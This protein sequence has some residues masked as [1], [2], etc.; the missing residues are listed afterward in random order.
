MMSRIAAKTSVTLLLVVGAL[1]ITTPPSF[2]DAE[3]ILTPSASFTLNA[4]DVFAVTWT[5][6]TITDATPISEWQD[7]TLTLMKDGTDVLTIGSVADDGHYDWLV[8]DGLSGQYQ[9]RLNR[10]SPVE[11]HVSEAFTIRDADLAFTAPD[12]FEQLWTEGDMV[13]VSW[14]GDAGSLAA[15]DIALVATDGSAETYTIAS[16]IDPASGSVTTQITDAVAVR[17]YE[18]QLRD[19]TNFFSSPIARL[20]HDIW[21]HHLPGPYADGSLLR[22]EGDEVV[23]LIKVLPNGKEFKRHVLTWD[24][25]IWYPHLGNFWSAVTVVPEGTMDNYTTSAWIRLPLTQDTET[26]KVYEVNADAT[27]HWLTCA[28]SDQCGSIWRGNGGDPDGIYTVN[29]TELNFYT[30]GL[31]VFFEQPDVPDPIEEEYE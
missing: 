26:W 14:E 13:T 31:N 18:I 3:G 27:K 11:S 7:V 2:G 17:P 19:S 28:V 22:E 25:A 1:L 6:A 21:V 16:G 12:V 8:P 4:G 10:T 9:M 5:G 29:A 23:W 24:M 20:A 30:T 15:V